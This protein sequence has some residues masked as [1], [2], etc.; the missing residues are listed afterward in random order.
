MRQRPRP[1]RIP[2]PL[3]PS[4]LR[5]AQ[6]PEFTSGVSAEFLNPG[7]TYIVGIL[8]VTP[9][10]FSDGNRFY[11]LSR[12]IPH[13]LDMIED[14]ADIIDIGG[15]STRPGAKP[16]PLNEEL[17][18]VIPVIEYLV[19]IRP[20]II[21]SIDTYKAK[22]AEAAIQAGARMVND[23]SGLGMDEQ[24]AEVVARYKAPL[25]MMHI[26]GTPRDMQVNPRYKNLKK[27]MFDYF[28]QRIA[29]ALKRGVK[30]SQIIIDPGLGFGK[31]LEDNYKI[32]GWVDELH[33]LGRPIM[34]GPS[35]K[36]FIGKVLHPVRSGHKR[37]NNTLIKEGLSLSDASN[38][39]G[40]P[41][42]ERLEG[43]AAVVAYAV[44]KGIQFLR[45]HDVKEMKRVV[46]IAEIIL[47]SG[48]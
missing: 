24:M 30:K 43:T 13:A 32:L 33:K 22:V 10:S 8:N 40:L 34:L 7:R 11:K 23:I 47:R 35:R 3:K 41:P 27:E 29:Y 9:D 12:S 38:G 4:G 36:S 18:R 21:I 42:E 46:T 6:F 2:R 26:K 45:V 37:E 48:P 16:L 31:R 14:G 28:R 19:R 15:E 39:A 25:I 20:D 5:T 17:K 1:I 44:F